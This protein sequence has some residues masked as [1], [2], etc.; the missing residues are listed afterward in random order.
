MKF[1][2]KSITTNLAPLHR[3]KILLL[4]LAWLAVS[5][6]AS[7]QSDVTTRVPTPMVKIDQKRATFAFL[8][9]AVV[10]A[11]LKNGSSVQTTLGELSKKELE[12]V[13]KFTGWGRTWTDNAGENQVIADLISFSKDSAMFQGLDGETFEVPL[14]RISEADQKFINDR[15]KSNKLPERFRAKVIGVMDGDT[16]EV[17]LYDRPFRIRLVGIDAP[18]SSQA[19]GSR[20]KQ[21]LSE[22]AFG[23]MIVG[24]TE[25]QDDYGRNLCLLAVDGV[26]VDYEMLRE[27][28]A[29]HYTHFS[30]DPIRAALEAEAKAD[31]RNLWSGNVQMP[32]WEYRRLTPE[33]QEALSP[34]LSN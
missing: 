24:F 4:M 28:L 19:F 27:G 11:T 17:L 6:V 16:I 22:L 8:D 20:S 33:Q 21:K 13:M 5:T 15:R 31:K 14:D 12:E 9:A 34:A 7:A 2:P 25:D 26:R 10:T 29:W 32:P 3:M 18:E 23:K 1:G 30:D